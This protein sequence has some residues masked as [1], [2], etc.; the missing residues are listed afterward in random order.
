[1]LNNTIG[2]NMKRLRDCNEMKQEEL[3]EYL[4]IRRQTLSA[5]ETGRCIPN[6]YILL[7]I[8]KIFGVSVDELIRGVEL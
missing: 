6:I 8:S 7:Q 5:Y 3:A 4:N 2:K 1:M